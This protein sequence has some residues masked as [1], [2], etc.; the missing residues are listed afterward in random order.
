MVFCHHVPFYQTIIL[1]YVYVFVVS[2]K[3]LYTH[4]VLLWFHRS[5]VW[6]IYF[7]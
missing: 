3:M 1:G 7:Q 6:Q 4:G 5:C 2:Y